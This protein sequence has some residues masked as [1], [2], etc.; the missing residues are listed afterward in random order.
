MNIKPQ[1][2]G[3]GEDQWAWISCD[4]PR[5]VY[6]LLRFWAGEDSR[7]QAAVRYQ[8]NLLR[9]NGWP[10]AVAPE[11]G[12]FRGPGRKADPCPYADLVMLQ[13]LSLLPETG[14]DAARVGAET[15]LSLWDE[16]KHRRPY[17]FALGTGFAKLKA[18]SIWYDLLHVPDVLSSY[19]WLK[20]DRRMEEMTGLVQSKADGL[21]RYTPESIWTAWKEWEFGQKKAP[22]RWIT[23]IALRLLKR[24][25]SQ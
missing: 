4:A 18:P 17:L 25:G 7:V 16:W 20:G 10:C 5:V 23:L 12:K 2:G 19:P 8:K 24:C 13:M 3:S 1:Y 11:L 22:S 6:A 9:E 21:G 14:G 15:L